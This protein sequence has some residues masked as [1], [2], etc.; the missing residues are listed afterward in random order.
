MTSILKQQTTKIS[1]SFFAAQPR[2]KNVD[3]FIT[4]FMCTQQANKINR[5][6]FLLFIYFLDFL[7]NHSTIGLPQILHFLFTIYFCTFRNVVVVGN[8]EH[9]CKLIKVKFLKLLN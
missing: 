1:F 2:R 6:S 3:L 9:I 7:C 8:T 5:C 4:T